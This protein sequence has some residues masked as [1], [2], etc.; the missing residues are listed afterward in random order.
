MITRVVISKPIHV[1]RGKNALHWPRLFLLEMML[2]GGWYANFVAW[3]VVLI[4]AIYFVE[5]ITRIAG[6]IF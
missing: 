3:W 6:L 1:A 4:W 5:G 2:N